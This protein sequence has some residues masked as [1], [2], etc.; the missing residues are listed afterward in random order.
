MITLILLLVL[1]AACTPG[2]GQEAG[3][4]PAGD[5]AT[6]EPET[7]TTEA[8]N[9]RGGLDVPADAAIVFRQEGGLEGIMEQWTIY[10]DGRLVDAAGNEFQVPAEVVQGL[11]T[12]AA[13]SGFFDMSA[14]YMP[15]DTCCDRFTYWLA[16]RQGD[17]LH[18]VQ[19]LSAEASV[20]PAFWTVLAA[21]QGA[22]EAASAGQ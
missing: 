7:A 13:S 9:G 3:Q 11:V 19:A 18:T 5:T 4:T 15:L 22:V 17:Q 1:L 16:V 10:Q 21:V 2:T 14:S 12:T 20:P 6:R 8:T